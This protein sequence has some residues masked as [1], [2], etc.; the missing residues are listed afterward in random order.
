V[1]FVDNAEDKKY[2]YGYNEV[3]AARHIFRQQE[4]IL[5][6]IDFGYYGRVRHQTEHTVF[7]GL[8]EKREDN[9]TGEEIYRKMRH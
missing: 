9:V 4:E 3:N 2:R 8:R 6:H 7:C 1:N 5:R